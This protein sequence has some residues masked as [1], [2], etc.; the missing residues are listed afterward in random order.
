MSFKKSL[1]DDDNVAPVSEVLLAYQK[2][3]QGTLHCICFY[4]VFLKE[5]D[6]IWDDLD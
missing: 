6:I 2:A 1:T 3:I 4:T 5:K